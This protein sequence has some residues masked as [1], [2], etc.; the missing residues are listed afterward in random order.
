ML[1]YRHGFHAGNHGDVLK[2]ITQMLILEKL[3]VKPKPFVY[4]DIHSAGGC[5]DLTS[6]QATKTNEAETGIGRLRNAQ[7][8][9]PVI[10]QYLQLMAPFLDNNQYPGSP[11][12][13][14]TCM[15]DS[16]K[17]VFMELHN[18]EI[19]NLRRQ[20]RGD[21]VSIHHR[22]G[23][24]GLIA[25]TPPNPARGMVLIDPPYEVADEYDTLVKTLESVLK[26]WQTGIYAI[27]Y[28]LLSSRAGAKQGKSEAMLSKLQSLPVKNLLKVELK[29]VNADADAGMYGSGMAII[30]APWQLDSQLSEVL[31][32]L[33][34]A[35]SDSDGAGFDVE[36][37]VEE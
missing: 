33:T 27:W 3:A 37:L 13:A 1:S 34:K 9:Q 29:V 18:D 35:L 21:N 22:D 32:E 5:Y 31:P 24:E 20:C 36:W 23:F 17:L 25:L 4:F 7:I 6:E 12:I 16:D 30:N 10:R 11:M 14:K 15:R 28:P 19:H 26:R 2:H 8:N